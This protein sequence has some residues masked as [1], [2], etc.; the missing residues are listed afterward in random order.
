MSYAIERFNQ[1]AVKH[2]LSA[3]AILLW[4]HLFFTMKRKNQ[5]RYVQQHT[6]VLMAVLNI[7][8]QG[9]QNMRQMLVDNGLLEVQQDE[10]QQIF[11]TLLMD[12]KLVEETDER[13]AVQADE[14]PLSDAA[15][16]VL[17]EPLAC[18]EHLNVNSTIYQ[19]I[20]EKQNTMLPSGDIILNGRCQVYIEQFCEKFGPAMKL[21]LLDWADMRRKNGWT[22]TLWGLEEALKKLIAL[23]GGNGVKMAQIAAQSVK[24]RWKGFWE[25]KI[26][27]KPCGAKL[28]QQEA[29]E[30]R[31]T[32]ESRK[33]WEKQRMLSKCKPEGRDL[34]FLER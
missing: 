12:G 21:E 10:H 24:R 15:I 16:Q 34:S 28:L 20:S 8:R 7:S 11:Y 2:S 9:L 27:P 33:P 30:Q 18:P 14:K 5:F 23:S 25:V 29:E 19:P 26:K 4:Q 3:G 1:Y 13:K 17:K 31:I 22:L 32:S 6:S